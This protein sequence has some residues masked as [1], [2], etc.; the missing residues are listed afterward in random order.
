MGGLWKGKVSDPSVAEPYGTTIRVKKASTGFK[1]STSY[2]N[3]NCAGKLRGKKVS[4]RHYRF[5]ETIT[6]N[7]DFCGEKWMIE[8][9]LRRH[10]RADWDWDDGQGLT[11]G[12]RL[13]RV[14]Q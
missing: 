9:T 10:H 5:T 7:T 3:I 11:A 14:S 8:V 13:K 12:G 2:E 6:E 1:G 4:K